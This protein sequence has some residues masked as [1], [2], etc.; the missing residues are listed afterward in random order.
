MK[1]F[2]D[3]KIYQLLDKGERIR[4]LAFG[5][6]N[7]Q[8]FLA[9]AHWFDYVSLGF[10][11][12]Y[13]GACGQFIEC[14]RSGDTTELLL[15][16]FDTD[17]K[18]YEP[19]LTLLTVGVNDAN[20]ARNISGEVYKANLLKIAEKIHRC[21][22]EVIFQTY[23]ACDEEQ[24]EP[25][26]VTTIRRNMQILRDVAAETGSALNDNYSRWDKL[27][28]KNPQLYRLLMRDS[29]HVNPD[30]NCVIGL[31]LIRKFGLPLSEEN[32]KYCSVGLFAQQYLDTL[33]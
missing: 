7:T 25:D 19:H 27:R 18:H 13:G 1:E 15:E 28:L 8:R 11:T 14:G 16:R 12:T 6:S 10:K 21:G 32:W 23:Y 31:D 4:V 24:L 9:G 26:F 33:E 5:S 30:G 17:V 20:P 2:K 3:L 29:L 22:G